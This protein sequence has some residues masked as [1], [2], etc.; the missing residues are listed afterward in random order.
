MGKGMLLAIVL[1][2]V[3][4]PSQVF[5]QDI[6]GQWEMTMNFGGRP[7]YATLVISKGTGGSLTGTWSGDELSNVRFDGQRLTFTRTVTMGDQE[8]SLN[9]AGTLKDGKI[10]GLMSSDRGEFEVDGAR[11]KPKSPALGRWAMQ[12]KVAD[13]D[14][15]GTLA[16]SDGPDGALQGQWISERGEHS[17]S[18]VRFQNGRL[19]FD[20]TSKYGDRQWESSFEGEIKG[21]QLTGNFKSQRGEMPAVGER[22]GAPLIGK[23]EVTTTSDRGTRTR[24][25]T[26]YPDLTGR[27]E[28]FGGA[29]IPISNLKLE[30]NTVTFALETGWGDQVF[31]SDFTAKLEGRTLKGQITSDRGTTEVDGKKMEAASPLVGT[32][33]FTRETQRGTR[34]STLKINQDM[35]ATYAARDNEIPVADLSVD[36]DQVSFKVTMTYNN[37][38]VTME[39]KGKVA[40]DTLTGEWTT[41][42]GTREAIGKKAQ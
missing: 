35:T 40:G 32:W 24:V 38:E 21:D 34:T 23:W 31:R 5:A 4:A 26:I 19:T 30:G 36:G 28:W 17:V 11:M 25:L 29:E 13:R 18:N 39:F 12:Y 37:N 1:A 9:Y 15:T 22:V 7:S 33:E 8:F 10:M 20:R 2:L 16:I 6:T 42:R 41:A 27:Y 3:A 14:A